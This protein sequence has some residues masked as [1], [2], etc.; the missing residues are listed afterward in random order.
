MGYAVCWNDKLQEGYDASLAAMVHSSF[1]LFWTEWG[2]AFYEQV[3]ILRE[4]KPKQDEDGNWRIPPVLILDTDDNRD[5]IHPHNTTFAVHGVRSYPSTKLLTPGRTLWSV[6]EDTGKKKVLWVDGQTTEGGK[7]FDIARNLHDMSTTHKIYRAVDGMTC[8]SPHHAKYLRE[9]VGVKNVHFFP[10][11]MVPEHYHSYP[12]VPHTGT[13]ILW[14]GGSSHIIDWY[15]LRHAVKEV[16]ERHPDVKWVIFG[17]KDEW[18]DQF[19]PASAVEF[20][21]WVE[22]PAY[23]LKRG[24]LQIDINLCPLADNFFNRCKSAIKWYEGSMWDKPEATLAANVPPFS[25]EMV[26]GETGLLYDD[27]TDFAEK[28]SLLIKDQELRNRLAHNAKTWV[29]TNRG[30]Q[31]TIPP[32]W[33]FYQDLHRQ[34]IGTM[35]LAQGAS[36]SEIKRLAVQKG[37]R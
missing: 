5:Y 6:D 22:Y 33:D 28:L 37:L 13:R 14:Q 29:L 25:D 35:L 10:N 4:M 12:L 11:T 36:N 24:L 27:P 1:D 8:A 2:D 3:K 17:Q 23:K 20:H 7:V 26:D 16:H 30:P 19:L 34:R 32:L 18:V 21:S 31:A 9:V 15:P